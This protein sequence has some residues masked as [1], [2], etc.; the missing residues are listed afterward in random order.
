VIVEDAQSEKRLLKLKSLLAATQSG[1]R[2]IS[3]EEITTEVA[4]YRASR[5]TCVPG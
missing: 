1:A 3:D 5:R 4:A 2:Q